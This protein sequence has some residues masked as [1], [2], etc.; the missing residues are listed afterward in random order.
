MHC[1]TAQGL[2]EQSLFAQCTSGSAQKL[3]ENRN[4]E[5]SVGFGAKGIGG[6]TGT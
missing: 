4:A 2:I 1:L 3:L 5:I 6:I